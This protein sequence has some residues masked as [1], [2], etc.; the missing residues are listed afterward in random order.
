MTLY[1]ESNNNKENYK[2]IIKIKTRR[3]VVDQ[4]H[5]N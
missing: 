3:K 1:E 5:D 4:C 2:I